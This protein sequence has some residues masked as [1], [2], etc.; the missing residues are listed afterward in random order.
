MELKEQ[1]FEIIG[2]P[3][4]SALAT[5]TAD[6]KPWVRYVMTFADEALTLRCATHAGARKVAQISAQPEVHVTCGVTN[7]M[8]MKPYVQ[9]QA[10]AEVKTDA[11]TRHAFWNP[12]LSNIFDGPDDPQFAVLEMVPYRIELCNPPSM[13]HAVWEAS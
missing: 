5:M 8:E 9:I 12:Q 7:P 4:L 2:R 13:E 10:R 1:I 11:A 3:Q 6:A